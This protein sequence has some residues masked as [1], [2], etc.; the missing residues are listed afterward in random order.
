MASITRTHSAEATLTGT[1]KDDVKLTGA[2]SKRLA[3]TNTAGSTSLMIAGGLDGEQTAPDDTTARWRVP[4]GLTLEV[5]LH[6]AALA[7]DDLW[8]AIVGD[9]NTYVVQFL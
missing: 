1:A 4:A 8:L 2:S 6:D 7:G 9:G 3:V 5:D